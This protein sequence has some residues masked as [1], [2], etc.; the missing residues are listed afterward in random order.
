MGGGVNLLLR[1]TDI[2]LPFITWFLSPAVAFGPDLYLS[3]ESLRM[4]IPS[5][6]VFVAGAGVAPFN[7]PGPSRFYSFF[8]SANMLGINIIPDLHWICLKLTL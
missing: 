8:L 5:Q 1:K 3:S 6:R 4:P 7:Q 2:L